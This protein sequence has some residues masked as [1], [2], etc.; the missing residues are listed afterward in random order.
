MAET[1]GA[2]RRARRGSET[3]SPGADT[4]FASPGANP[5][6]RL[7]PGDYTLTVERTGDSTGA[8]RF[9]FWKLADAAPL[10]L[11]APVSGTLAPA[12]ETDL[13]R[14][15]ADPNFVKVPIETLLSAAHAESLCAKV[16]PDR[17]SP[18]GSG[19][20]R[21]SAPLFSADS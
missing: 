1:F 5:V 4:S 6:L 8:Y 13:Y 11:G 10:T 7:V 21:H 3:A 18:T 2:V 12:D 19:P 16:D 9:A 14:F 17:A 15:N 20:A